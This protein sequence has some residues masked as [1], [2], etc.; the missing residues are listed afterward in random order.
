[1]YLT[2]SNVVPDLLASLPDRVV[3]VL[4]DRCPSSSHP[5]LVDLE[6]DGNPVPAVRYHSVSVA[7]MFRNKR[8]I[9]RK[10]ILVELARPLLRTIGTT[11]MELMNGAQKSNKCEV[12]AVNLLRYC[13]MRHFVQK[14][15]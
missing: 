3:S 10:T 8:V 1:M 5:A 7:P 11:S 2:A 15:V 6:E 13:L 14:K 12:C 4:H 9:K